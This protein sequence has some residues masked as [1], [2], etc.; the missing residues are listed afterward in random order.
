MLAAQAVAA[1]RG[2][3]DLEQAITGLEN[4]VADLQRIA[5]HFVIGQ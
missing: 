1:S 4:V 2:Q 3:V 5:R